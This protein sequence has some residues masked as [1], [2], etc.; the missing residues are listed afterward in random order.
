MITN[1]DK[2]FFKM[3][4]LLA[5]SST[6]HKFR[7]GAVIIQN[8]DILST[9]VNSS[10]TH[11]LQMKYNKYR[12]IK[13]NNHCVHAEMNAIVKT[14]N[15]NLLKGAIIYISRLKENGVGMSRPCK[16][17]MEALKDFGIRDICYS[18]DIGY[19][20]EYINAN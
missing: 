8:G 11:P 17:C 14:S 4:T 12:N 1:R 2:I 16:A 7:M 20:K 10:K 18:T 5:Q 9:G 3:A 6:H 19:A 15:K 13:I